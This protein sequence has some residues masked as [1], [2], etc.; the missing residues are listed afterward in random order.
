[1]IG[2]VWMKSEKKWTFGA[3]RSWKSSAFILADD[4]LVVLDV[5]KGGQAEAAGVPIGARVLA[6]GGETVTIVEDAIA[7]LKVTS[8]SSL[9]GLIATMC[10]RVWGLLHSYS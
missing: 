5:T 1:M 6:V 2:V 3:P 8:V 4:T 9:V 7:A 10:V